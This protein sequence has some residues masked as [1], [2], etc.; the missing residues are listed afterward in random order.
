MRTHLHVIAACADRK[1]GTPG[2]TRRLRA[3]DHGP[4]RAEKWVRALGSVR[5]GHVEA[6]DLYVGNHWSAARAI[7]K[8][9]EDAGWGRASL[10]VASA[11]YG[12]VQS[13]EP[14][15][16]YAATFGSGHEDSVIDPDSSD[17]T[18]AQSRRWWAALARGRDGAKRIAT[19]ASRDRNAAILFVGSRAYVD[20]A[21]ED[22]VAAAGYLQNPERLVI[23]TGE[24]PR[25][26][27]LHPHAIVPPARVRGAVKGPLTAL[28]ARLASYLVRHLPPA[29]WTAEHA[30]ALTDRVAAEARVAAVPARAVMN[31]DDVRKFVRKALKQD[32]AATASR[33]LRTLRD[34][35]H[36]C[37]Q[38]RF[39]GLF[40]DVKGAR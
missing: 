31:D 1:R 40:W 7:P 22:L 28:H 10:W 34:G 15:V 5:E 11:G 3:H 16:P 25:E 20:A 21:A 12:L 17:S 23:V 9:A 18:E 27:A 24:L 36:A 8:V 33:L 4:K 38:K 2:D 30:R 19:L 13:T 29:S 37:E 6:V 26:E 32:A 35:G 14:L 39:K